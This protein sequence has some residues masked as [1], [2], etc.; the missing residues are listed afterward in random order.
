MIILPRQARDKHR[1]STQKERRFFLQMMGLK[2]FLTKGIQSFFDSKLSRGSDAAKPVGGKTKNGNDLIWLDQDEVPSLEG[3]KAGV[4][5]KKN[6]LLFLTVDYFKKP[7]C[8]YEL[9]L[10]LEQKKNVSRS[11]SIV[12]SSCPASLP[13]ASFLFEYL[14]QTGWFI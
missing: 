14:L 11:R 10:A 7:F 1:E 8:R 13:T 2:T 9:R 4:K 5:R 12:S 6:F 3:M